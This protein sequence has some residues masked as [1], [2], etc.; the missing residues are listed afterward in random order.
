ML[1]TTNTRFHSGS[2]DG[3]RRGCHQVK[4]EHT[5][6]A[7]GGISTN[8]SSRSTTFNEPL[9]DLILLLY[10]LH[11]TC[12]VDSYIDVLLNMFFYIPSFS[13]SKQLLA[14]LKH[15]PILILDDLF[16]QLVLFSQ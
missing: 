3:S 11:F 12:Q 15:H 6:E 1:L 4:R 7:D 13:L 10:T 9:I 2:Y 8:P 5:L 16:H 14:L